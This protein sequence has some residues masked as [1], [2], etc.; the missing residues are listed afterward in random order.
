MKY[1]N[2]IVD[3]LIIGSY[4]SAVKKT[5]AI[6]GKLYALSDTGE[7]I[8]NISKTVNKLLS[9]KIKKLINELKPSV[10]VCTHPFPVQMLS[11]LRR[12]GRVNI[13]IVAVVTDYAVHPLWTFASLDAYVVP[14]EFLKLE[15]IEKGFS[16]DII[17]PLGIPVSTNFLKKRDKSEILTELGLEEKLTVLL[18]GG[19]LGFGEVED[20]FQAL[21]HCEKDLQIIA[22]TGQNLKL[23]KQLENYSIV[24]GKNVKILSYTEK[25]SDIMDISDLIITKPGGMTITESII[26]ELPIVIMSPIPGQEEKNAQ[27]LL[28]NGAAVRITQNDDVASV[29]K[30]IIDDPSGVLKMKEKA[31]RLAKPNSCPDIIELLEKLVKPTLK[32]I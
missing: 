24:T 7:N 21:L 8:N 22:V 30:Q 3:K 32:T 4:L 10:I 6:Y 2:P 23:K 1:I 31:R 27:F 11:N 19:S 18:M 29:L 12:K 16:G 15:A 20:V 13:P 28:S 17:Y 26:K 14:H 25:V 5:P 9:F